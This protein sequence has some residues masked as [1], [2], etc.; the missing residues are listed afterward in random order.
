MTLNS[1]V[2]AFER[3]RIADRAH[4]D[5]RARQ[6]RADEIDVDRESAANAAADRA[7]DD[8]ALLERLFEA[9]PSASAL[10]FLARQTRLAEAV[11]D[12]IE[13]HFDVVAD[14][15]F[16]LAAFVEKLIGRDDGL[17]LQSGVDDHHVGVNADDDAGRE[18]NRS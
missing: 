10:G 7:R 12:G 15:D 14:F 18:W 4:V 11:L 3:R 6:E 2:V 8:L 13:R 17:G 1:S 16:E 9:S 5:E